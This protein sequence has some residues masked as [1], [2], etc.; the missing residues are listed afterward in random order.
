M[1][2]RGNQMKKLMCFVVVIC[3]LLF[4]SVPIFAVPW[5]DTGSSSRSIMQWEGINF[6]DVWIKSFKLNL[7]KLTLY[8]GD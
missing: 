6:G 2:G 8:R 5:P 3:V 1:K 7:R 4:C